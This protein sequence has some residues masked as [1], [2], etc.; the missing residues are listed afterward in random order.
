M[1]RFQTCCVMLLTLIACVGLLCGTPPLHAQA[2]PEL[3]FTLK[4]I[5]PKVWAAI[6]NRQA[7][8]PASAN[9][10]V[11]VGD[12]GVAVVDSFVSA[13][14]GA[15]LLAEIR[16]L[17]PLPVK[18]VVNTHYHLDHVAGNRVFADLGALVVAHH[19]VRGWI[20]PENLKFFGKDVK[21]E[22]KAFIEGLVAPSATYDGAVDLYLGSREVRVRHL[23]GHTGGDSVVIVPD[24]KVVAGGDLFW[25]HS[26]PNTIDASTGSWV[27]TLDALTKDYAGY[28]FVPG[29]GDVG[30]AQDVAAFRDYLATLRKLVAEAQAKGLG[31]DHLVQTVRSGL[32]DTYGQWDFFKVLG[33]RNI[34]EMDSELKGTKRVPVAP[35]KP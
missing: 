23:P 1:A 16:R 15:A 22:Q 6:D 4:S 28:T 29:H 26:L 10:V 32:S 30:T 34:V 5:G 12:D 11:V 24:A 27:E 19:N 31:G 9:A 2:A 18:F 20:H 21:P 35:A 33:D 13:E 14:A 8:A 3:P 17:T 25:R 7:K